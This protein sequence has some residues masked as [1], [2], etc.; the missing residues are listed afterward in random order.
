MSTIGCN[1]HALTCVCIHFCS[2]I[3]HQELKNN[4][5]P[6]AISADE[7]LSFVLKYGPLFQQIPHFSNLIHL[8]II[9]NNHVTMTYLSPTF[10]SA[11]DWV[12]SPRDNRNENHTSKE[13]F[14]VESSDLLQCSMIFYNNLKDDEAFRASLRRG[15]I[16][17]RE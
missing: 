5:L 8:T 2:F 7:S 3:L 9:F 1:S 10:H 17:V 6:N 13:L 12:C 15:Q 16:K 11:S 4:Y 14:L